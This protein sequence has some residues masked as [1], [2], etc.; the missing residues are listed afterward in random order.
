MP[1][2]AQAGQGDCPEQLKLGNQLCFPLYA[3][4][5]LVTRLYQPLLDKA[6]LTYPQYVV[7]MILWESGPLAVN[8]IGRRAM[9]NSNT[10]TPLLKRLEAQA[11][12]LRQRDACDE[13]RVVIRLTEAGLAL[14]DSCEEIPLA[15]LSQAGLRVEDTLELKRLLDALL[16]ELEKAV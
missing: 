2:P 13:R 7:L 11:L 12:I 3:A 4:S 1:E 6:G 15:L 9:L 8:E 10:L 5:R 16:P 14:R